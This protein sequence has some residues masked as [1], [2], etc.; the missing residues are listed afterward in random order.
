VR[1]SAHYRRF[2]KISLRPPGML[3]VVCYRAAFAEPTVLFVL[4]SSRFTT[5]Q[6]A[7]GAVGVSA[8]EW[9]AESPPDS[10]LAQESTS[11]HIAGPWQTGL[12]LFRSD[13]DRDS[14]FPKAS[15]VRWPE[16]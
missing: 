11:S 2:R 4:V 7:R 5:S 6:P 10:T 16:S 8:Q 13:A 1:G 9:S 3:R 15:R 12:W 14:H